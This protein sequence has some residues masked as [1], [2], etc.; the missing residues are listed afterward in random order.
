MAA[1]AP[2]PDPGGGS[3]AEV[4]KHN[5]SATG[6]SG[7]SLSA[8][9]EL[10]SFGASVADS[11]RNLRTALVKGVGPATTTLIKRA[12]PRRPTRA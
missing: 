1:N 11:F 10:L 9:T 12:R 8:V 3:G 7:A 5:A 2:K 4:L 6:V